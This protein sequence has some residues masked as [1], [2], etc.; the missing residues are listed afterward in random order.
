MSAWIHVRHNDSSTSHYSVG[1][2]GEFEGWKMS[3]HGLVFKRADGTRTHVL[4]GSMINFDVEPEKKKHIHEWGSWRPAGVL[5]TTGE[6]EYVR[7]C[8][9]GACQE[10]E[11]TTDVQRYKNDR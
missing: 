7:Q 1:S 2:G 9:V 11:E 3:A 10:M 8:V 5:R 4:A 6:T